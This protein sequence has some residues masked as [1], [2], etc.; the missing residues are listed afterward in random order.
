MDN[1][2]EDNLDD[3]KKGS[4]DNLQRNNLD[5]LQ[6]DSLDDVQRDILDNLQRNYLEDLQR[7][8]LDNVHRDS[9]DNLQRNSL[10]DLQRGNLVDFQRDHLNDLSL[11]DEKKSENTGNL[12]HE[13]WNPLVSTQATGEKEPLIYSDWAPAEHFSSG[14]KD[15]R[16]SHVADKV[17]IL[18][19]LMSPASS[20]DFFLN[21]AASNEDEPFI[22]VEA[23]KDNKDLLVTN[24]DDIMGPHVVEGTDDIT[25]LRQVTL[26]DDETNEHKQNASFQVS[27]RDLYRSLRQSSAF[28]A[29]A[30]LFKPLY[31]DGG[32]LASSSEK[33]EQPGDFY[34]G[35]P[36][37]GDPYAGNPSA[38]DP[39]TGDPSAGDLYTGDPYAGDPS[40]GDLYAGDPSVGDPSAGD[41]LGG[42][43]PD[44][45]DAQDGTSNLPGDTTADTPYVT[46][47]A[48]PEVKEDNLYTV[49]LT[50]EKGSNNPED[51]TSV[52]QN[53]IATAAEEGRRRK[54]PAISRDTFSHFKEKIS[55]HFML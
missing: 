8:N 13:S 41:P 47:V 3:L 12:D 44:F 18:G 2:L 30:E 46:A 36:S 16:P 15:L 38:G 53:E 28:F 26:E 23:S 39:T 50:E 10:D 52:G 9:L 5:N 19:M 1:L 34:A 20:D 35:D 45:V 51:W 48:G 37:G 29:T 27:G 49:D 24:E 42:R 7:G 14:Q 6:N 32:E 21:V 40:T 17:D 22:I 11:Y 25:T 33:W 43:V 4:L 54:V 31:V 55:H